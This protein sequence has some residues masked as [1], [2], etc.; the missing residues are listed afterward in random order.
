MNSELKHYG[1]LGMRWGRRS[2]G[3]TTSSKTKK[4]S[5]ENKKKVSD[6]SDSELRE[7]V[8]RIQMEQ[9][10]SKLTSANVNKGKQYID[11]LIKTGATIAAVTTTGLTIYN[12]AGKIK[13]ILDSTP[14]ITKT[15]K[16]STR[17]ASIIAKHVNRGVDKDIAGAFIK[18]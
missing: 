6:M 7:K 9:Q 4:A 17:I 16:D 18:F 15:A 1:V 10:Y 14:K 11:R 12:N 5:K 2:G 13:G 8:N 3:S